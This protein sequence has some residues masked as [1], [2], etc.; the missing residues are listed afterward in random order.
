MRP[1]NRWWIA[2]AGVCMQMALGA[3]YAW[4][5]FRIP[6]V[7]EF[8]WSISQVALT[9]SIS[10]FFLGA[11]SVVGGLWLNRSGPPNRGD[12]GR[13]SLGWRSL[14]HQFCREQVV[15]AVCHL[16]SDRGHRSRNRL[17]RSRGGSREVV[18]RTPRI[19]Y[20]HCSRRFW[21]WV[22]HRSPA[23]WQADANRRSH[24]DV[25]VS[26]HRLWCGRNLRRLLHAEPSRRLETCWMG[27][28][29]DPDYATIGS[30]L[31]PW[32]SFENLAT[33]WALC[34]LLSINTIAGIS[35][36]SPRPPPVSESS[37]R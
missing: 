16:R 2:L 24:A 1:V 20:G 29:R 6:L 5:V 14:S 25:C 28:H 15:D 27:S 10:W 34:A 7:K 30:G 35:V 17:H 23:G 3:G 8:G 9:F 31:Y 19:D 13:S 22:S 11:M 4:S 32:R 37:A 12:D 36:W 21:R 33:W 18:S 26:W